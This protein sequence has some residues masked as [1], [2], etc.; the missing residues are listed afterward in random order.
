MSAGVQH[1]VMHHFA[2]LKQTLLRHYDMLSLSEAT[3]MSPPGHKSLCLH[4][5]RA[6][7]SIPGSTSF[8]SSAENSCDKLQGHGQSLTAN[9]IRFFIFFYNFISVLCVSNFRPI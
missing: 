7:F 5:V 1:I 2:G 3:I 8:L 9:L 4:F 6:L